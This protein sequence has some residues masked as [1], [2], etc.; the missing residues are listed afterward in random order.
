MCIAKRARDALQELFLAPH[1]DSNWVSMSTRVQVQRSPYAPSAP[2]RCPW[3]CKIHISGTSSQKGSQSPQPHSIYRERQ[4]R[5]NSPLQRVV[6]EGLPQAPGLT[7]YSAQATPECALMGPTCR[8]LR[9]NTRLIL[10]S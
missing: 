6:A 5:G 3:K 1:W 8:C 9:V 2:E 7:R 4:R 10:C